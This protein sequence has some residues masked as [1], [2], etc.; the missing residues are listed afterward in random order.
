MNKAFD[1]D[2]MLM[3]AIKRLPRA[4][5]PGRDLWP[6]IASRLAPAANDGE[7]VQ[8]RW[9]RGSALVA[10]LAVALAVGLL[11]GRQQDISEPESGDGAAYRLPLQLALE[12]GE[13]EYQAAFREFLPVTGAGPMLAP[14]ALEDV[15]NSWAELRQVESALQAA[16]YEYPED[17][18]LN[19][20]LLDLRAQQ[21][22][23]MKQMA[24]LDQY[25]RR[26]I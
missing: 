24:V 17:A 5:R 11:L 1:N 8:G 4:M 23:F 26:R 14:E 19:R 25:S 21:L 22:G 3:A 13:R 10:S 7:G 12:V 18:Y 16:L 6:G 9:W 20:K 2:A 15:E